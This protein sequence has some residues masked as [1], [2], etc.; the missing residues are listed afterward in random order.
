[1][2]H[3][4]F[5]FG[6]LALALAHGEFE[7]FYQ[8]QWDCS[9]RRT[10]ALE[11]LVRWNH[12]GVLV[13]PDQFLPRMANAGLMPAL[14]K[15][16]LSQVCTDVNTL[17]SLGLYIEKVG[18]NF[19]YHQL[20]AVD[21]VGSV[22]SIVRNCRVD[23]SRIVLEITESHSF[24]N[25]TALVDI[26][27]ELQNRGFEFALDDFCTGCSCLSH[28]RSLPVQY[29]KLDRSFVQNIQ[30]NTRDYAI[31]K[32]LVEIANQLNIKTIAEG[33]E[34]SRQA[35]MLMALS[36]DSLQG[37]FFSKPQPLTSLIRL[38]EKENNPTL[39]LTA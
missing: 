10:T 35:D 9:T 3:Q 5:E 36:V 39:R 25:L 15:Y 18:V 37:Y 27:S 29:I 22:E 30:L 13:K 24:D 6:T 34:T 1:M 7:V 4:N 32:G 28:L 21:F 23:P 20:C 8:T 31:S 16:V 2:N 19:D 33:I 12:R 14:G 11:A 26:V 38:L 17:D